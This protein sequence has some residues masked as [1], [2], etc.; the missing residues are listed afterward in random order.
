MK[1]VVKIILLILVIVVTSV[2]FIKK[3][4][5]IYKVEIFLDDFAKHTGIVLEEVWVR[6]RNNQSKKEIINAINMN[7][8]DSVLFINL[9]KLKGKIDN[10]PWVSNSSIYLYPRGKIEIEIE[11]YIPVAVYKIND[12]HFLINEDGKKIINIDSDDYASLII[13]SG[14]NALQNM[15]EMKEIIWELKN[16]KFSLNKIERV[17]NRRWNIFFD[18]GF[19]AK[20]PSEEPKLALLRLENFLSKYDIKSEK[21]AFIDLRL[22][23]RVSIKYSD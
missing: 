19:Y 13:I 6:G 21:L 15:H 12:G 5:V 1:F 14:D 18:E 8:G 3:D 16:C 20:L 23:D 10:L 17:G 4:K 11:E 22:L 2:L 9:D 7:I